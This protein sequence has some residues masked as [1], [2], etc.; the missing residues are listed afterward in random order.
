MAEWMW[1]IAGPN[2]A[3][4]S[5]FAGRF[6][7]DLGHRHLITL[8][9]DER[10]LELR[11]KFADAAQNDLN[12]RA[13]IAVDQDVAA[14]IEA[15]QSF[16]VETVLSSGKYRDD[17]LGAKAKGFRFGLIYVSLHPPELS[18]LRVSERAAKGGHDVDPVTAV[19]RHHRSHAELRWFAPL[20]DLLMVFDNSAPAAAP[21]LLATRIGTQ[22]LQYLAPGVNPS[23]DRALRELAAPAQPRLD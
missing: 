12:L 5:S 23:V 20:A 1:L 17:V 19:A 9:A 8:N 6:L 22:P 4:K 13:A 2:G 14:C 18:P 7:R 10:T 11:K 3:G 15:G 16:V 21:I